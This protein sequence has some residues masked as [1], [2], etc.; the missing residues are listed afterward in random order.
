MVGVAP[1]VVSGVEELKVIC[2]SLSEALYLAV[3]AAS[4]IF[5][6]TLVL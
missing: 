6:S 2:W 1:Q 5:K 3:Q 4:D